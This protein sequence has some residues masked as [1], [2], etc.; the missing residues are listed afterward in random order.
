MLDIYLYLYLAIGSLF[1]IKMFMWG[2]KKHPTI[3]V[4]ACSFQAIF[5]WP[6]LA[7]LIV[8]YTIDNWRK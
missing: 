7:I 8:Y 1:A 6:I 3:I 4:T 2:F 5:T